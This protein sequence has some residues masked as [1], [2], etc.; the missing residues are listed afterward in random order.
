MRNAKW[1]LKKTFCCLLCQFL[2]N[3]VL[4]QDSVVQMQKPVYIEASLLYDFPQSYGLTV[5]M[6]RPFR[7]VIKNKVYHGKITSTQRDYFLEGGIGFYRY[8]FNHTGIFLFPLIGSRSV[9]A[10]HYHQF[11]MGI[12]LLRTFYDG[13]VYEVERSG[14]VKELPLFG[15]YYAI[16]NFSYAVGW[17][18]KKP[19]LQRF[20]IQAKPQLWLQFPYNS[21]MKPHLSFEFGVRY[22]FSNVRISTINRTK[23]KNK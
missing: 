14:N 9:H 12:G 4:A 8:P 7:S 17:Q 5:A 23:P 6:N 13:K 1:I 3:V 11:A 2:L 18:L 19:S 15:R 16:A 21:F 10:F 22:H 20:S